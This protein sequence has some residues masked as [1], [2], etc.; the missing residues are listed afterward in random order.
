MS[1]TETTHAGGFLISE[2]NGTLSRENVTIVSGETLAAGT[3]LGKITASGKY[4]AYDNAAADGTEVAA[5]V[6]YE[7]VDASAGDKPGVAIVR[8]AEVNANELGW[9]GGDS[10]AITAGKADLK[11]LGVIAR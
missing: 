11:A 6:L 4:A 1:L 2:A 3:V 5:G 7:A 9:S 10:T 8:Y